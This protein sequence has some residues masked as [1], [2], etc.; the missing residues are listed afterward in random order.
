V[1]IFVFRLIFL[2]F[3]WKRCKMG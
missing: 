2:Y 1:K 3:W